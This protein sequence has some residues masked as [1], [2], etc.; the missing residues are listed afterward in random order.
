LIQGAERRE[1]SGE[2][3]MREVIISIGFDAAAEPAHC[4]GVCLKVQLGDACYQ[5]PTGRRGYRGE[6]SLI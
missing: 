6:A 4:F 2:S 1:Y 3:K 5:Q